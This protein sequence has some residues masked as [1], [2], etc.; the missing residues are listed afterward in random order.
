MDWPSPPCPNP[1]ACAPVP[2]EAVVRRR[3]TR[4]LP[5]LRR[6]VPNAICAL[7][8]R[9]AYE[10]IMATILSAQCTDERVNLVTPLLFRKYPVA[11]RLAKAIPGDVE[12]II[13]STGF[14][15]AKTKS[16]IG[17]A[18]VL[19]RDHAGRVPATMEDL[20]RL[21]GVGRK[22]ANVV[23]GNAFGIAAGIVVDTHVTRLSHRLGL[24]RHDDPVKIE[25]DLMVLIP[26]SSWIAISHLLIHHGRRTCMARN[27]N[28]PGCAIRTLCPSAGKVKT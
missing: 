16:L 15:R 22:T 13:K 19:L 9:N 7:R 11:A 5:T 25:Q 24:T 12:R 23:L 3:V 6:A 10:L 26:K 21:P 20:V 28:C 14:F 18:T 4:L 27:P 2:A 1:G 17:C 8:H